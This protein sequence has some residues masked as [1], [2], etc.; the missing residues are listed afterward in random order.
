[1]KENNKN[2]AYL[3]LS[4]AA[5]GISLIIALIMFGREWFISLREYGPDGSQL[6]WVGWSYY[7][8]L[9]DSGHFQR[10][11]LNTVRFNVLF[12]FFAFV[13]AVL[14]GTGLRYVPSRFR[15]ALVML[16]LL[17]VFLPA[18][19]YAGWWIHQ[20]PVEVLLQSDRMMLLHPLLS[21]VKY[22]GIPLALIYALA[23]FRPEDR[24]LPLKG[25]GLF[26]LSILAFIGTGLFSLSSAFYNPAIADA[27]DTLDNFVFRTGP[28]QAQ[29]SMLAALN[30]MSTLLSAC[31]L[32]IMIVPL[33]LLIRVTLKRP[34]IQENQ[35]VQETAQAPQRELINESSLA[36]HAI[37]ALI[38]LVLFAVIYFSPYWLRGLPTWPEQF[39]GQLQLAGPFA[40]SIALSLLT[41]LG[42]VLIALAIA[43]VF[44]SSHKLLLWSASAALAIITLVSLH[45]R[46]ISEYFTIMNWGLLN[47]YAAIFL[48]TV[49]STA[50]IWALAAVWRI[51]SNLSLS[52]IVTSLSGLLL[53]QAAL[54]YGYVQPYLLYISDPGQF[55]PVMMYRMLT[56]MP[57]GPDSHSLEGG[58]ALIG[59]LVSTPALLLYLFAHMLLPGKR[60]LLMIAGGMKQ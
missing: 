20:L 21:A 56:K 54:H 19:V 3:I 30:V 29:Y 12:A 33:W 46:S 27:I 26:A 52:T 15:T 18:E 22:L 44:R 38:A 4:V 40:Y 45:T 50:A 31:A 9:L 41:A 53:I 5:L 34:A 36:H 6:A 32:L 49:F 25:A 47:T 8:Q 51:E 43:G 58:I 11:V 16:F 1:M 55:T 35:I 39:Q 10:V 42:S 17:I 28:T 48:T 59:F 24:W 7:Q 57:P 60:L 2:S 37:S 13:L 14:I 23:Y